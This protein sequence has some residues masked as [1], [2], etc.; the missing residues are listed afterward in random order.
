MLSQKMLFQAQEQPAK[1]SRVIRSVYND[2]REMLNDIMWL[3]GIQRFDVD[4]TY[5]I[6]RVWRGL[7]EPKRKFDIAPQSEN[8]TKGDS[9]NLP[10]E[11]ES[12]MSVY[13]DPPFIANTSQHNLGRIGKRFSAFRTMQDLQAMYSASLAEFWRILKP[14]GKL[15]FK[16]QDVVGKD[17]YQYLTHV[18]AI[19]QAESLGFYSRDLFILT[20]KSQ[21]ISAHMKIQKHARKSHSYYVVFLKGRSNIAC[22]GLAKSAA[23]R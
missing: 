13:F 21:M 10:L 5:S 14:K 4:P 9:R 18:F 23:N 6:G 3:Y 1:P 19:N 2:E 20:K 16:C 22:S 17:H 11:N 7:P 12:I 8:V 15:V